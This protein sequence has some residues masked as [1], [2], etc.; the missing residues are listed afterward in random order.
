MLMLQFISGRL[1]TFWNL[2]IYIV[3]LSVIY[4]FYSCS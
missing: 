3:W 2:F 1:I 4:V